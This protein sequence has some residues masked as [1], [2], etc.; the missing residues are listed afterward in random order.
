MSLYRPK[1]SQV[2]VMDFVFKGQRIRESTGMTSKTRAREVQD[3]RKQGLRDGVAGIRSQLKPLLFCTAAREFLEAVGF[4]KSAGSLAVAT[5]QDDRER[6]EESAK[7]ARESVRRILDHLLP[8]FGN[9]LLVDIEARD[10]ET[11]QAMRLHEKAANA[12]V[13]RD[14]GVLRQIMRKHGSWARIAPGVKMLPER[15][16]AGKAISPAQERILLLECYRSRSWVLFPFVVVALDTGGRFNTIRRLRW[17]DIDF[18]HGCIRFGKDKTVAGTGRVVPLSRRALSVLQSLASEFPDRKP[19]DYVFP[20]ERHK[21]FKDQALDSY[22]WFTRLDPSRPLGTPKTAWQTVKKNSR[23]YCPNCTSGVLADGLAPLTGYH[24]TDCSYET[25][26]LPLGLTGVRFHDL[27]HTA[28]SRMVAAKIPLPMIAKI[29]GWSPATLALMIARY[30][31]F[32][33]D[34]MRAA[35]ETIAG[36]DGSVLHE[37]A[38]DRGKEGESLTSSSLLRLPSR[39]PIRKSKYERKQLYEEVWNTP[40]RILARKYGVSDVALAKACRTRSVPLPPQGYWAKKPATRNAT[41]RPPL[42]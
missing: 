13:N 40:M 33:L 29:V 42:P 38:G 5:D 30:G 37:V 36:E 16:D 9:R 19:N 27:R 20:C 35:V 2:W 25:E 23:R 3:R 22:S 32:R 6:Y 39:L 21:V 14:V 15:R 17:K 31:H 34:E 11:Y 18:E 26:D 28:V 24:C 4:A 12:T 41:P 7:H 10:I 8:P 1:G